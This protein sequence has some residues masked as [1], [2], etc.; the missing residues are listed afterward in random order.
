MASMNEAQLEL[1]FKS[2]AK[3]EKWLDKN[4]AKSNGV[5]LKFAKKNSG[6]KSVNYTEALDVALCYGWIDSQMKGLDEKFYLQ[7]FTPRRSRSVWSK[8]NVGKIE[9]LI[10]EGKMKPAGLA[11]V[12]QAKADG[13]WSDAYEPQSRAVPP[14]DFQK[15]LDRNRKAKE[16]YDSLNSVNRYAFIF[17]LGSVKNPQPRAA[18]IAKFI[19][20]LEDQEKFHI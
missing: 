16:F 4:H 9:H 2:Q 13:R 7:K 18:K 11:Q 12:A 14:E 19:R 8:I 20:M 3:W 5:W 15:A 6:I 10:A 1:L 17:R